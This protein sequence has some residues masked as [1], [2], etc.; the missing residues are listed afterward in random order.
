MNKLEYK[1]KNLSPFKLCVIENFPFIEADFDAIT[2]YQLMCKI[3]EYLNKTIDS[4]NIL[5]TNINALNE[6]FN[7]LDVQ[8]EINNKL[9]EMAEN[10]QLADIISQY[11]RIAS[12]LAFNTIEDMKNS[13]NLFE[14]SFV[15]TYGFYSLG[16][17]GSAK[18]KVRKIKNTDVIDNTLL[19]ALNNDDSLVVELIIDKEMN[20]KQFGL[21]G[22]GITDE[23]ETLNKFFS[24]PIEKYIVNNGTYLIDGDIDIN[25]NSYVIFMENA[26]IKRKP[27]TSSH[28]YMLN[29]G[30]KNNI[31][32]ENAHLIGEK[33]EHLGTEGQW[34]Y[35]IHVFSSQYVNLKNCVI[36][37]TW[38]D[39]IYVGYSYAVAS[40]QNPKH[41]TIDNC[42]VINCS[43]NGYS[44]CS[45]EDIVLVNSYSYGVTRDYPKAGI[46]IEPEGP[47]SVTPYLKNI[48]IDNFSSD[49][50]DVGIGLI[51][52]NFKIENLTINNHY[53]NN[54]SVGFVIWG[55]KGESDIVYQN[56]HIVKPYGAGINVSK[57]KDSSVVIRNVV[58][59]SLR[60]NNQSHGY[61]GAVVIITSTENDG[62]LILDNIE[63]LHTYK[64]Y[65]SFTDIIVER[66]TGTFT[67]LILK[68]IY[69][70]KYVYLE[71]VEPTSVD[72]TNCQFKRVSSYYLLDSDKYRIANYM[73]YSSPLGASSTNNIGNSLPDGDYEVILTNNTGGYN[74]AVVFDN[75][76][77]VFNTS[78]YGSTPR[79]YNCN[80]RGGYLKFNK[81]GNIVTILENNGFSTN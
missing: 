35:G 81:T 76:I 65:F 27:T 57:E 33:E 11:L 18:Y 67:G 19:F 21:I 74:L 72:L 34:G 23:T 26:I 50:N 1:Y 39:G 49:S 60:K 24:Q 44:I 75:K 66:G 63:A 42:K 73:K 12:V 40:I 22:D 8:D 41:I 37:N 70:T 4:Q 20:T 52:N 64:D 9:D 80:Y 31:T 71:N 38:G 32:I 77:T 29:I 56:A 53:S 48:L 45:G 7:N 78:T 28:Y 58:V 68:N 47:D 62:N 16:D 36:E 17:G 25:S 55:I 61:D 43:R 15:K 14:N 54:E 79:T 10:G 5:I 13:T 59:D 69:T 51:T 2:N 6:W 3:V 30:N 46:D